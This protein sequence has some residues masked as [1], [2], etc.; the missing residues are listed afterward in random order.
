M[1]LNIK[2]LN[3]SALV[4]MVILMLSVRESLAASFCNGT[5][6][7]LTLKPIFQIQNIDLPIDSVSYPIQIGSSSYYSNNVLF[8]YCW[9]YNLR[10][11]ARITRPVLGKFNGQDVYDIGVPHMGIIV[12]IADSQEGGFAGGVN[13]NGNNLTSVVPPSDS[14]LLVA[15]LGASVKIGLIAFDRYPVGINVIPTIKI[16]ELSVVSLNGGVN[17]LGGV[18]DIILNGFSIEVKTKTCEL[19]QRNFT[20]PLQTVYKSMFNAINAEV[21]GGD[22]TLRLQC[23]PG[24]NVYATMTDAT[25]PANMTDILSLSQSSTAKGIKLKLYREGEGEAIKFGA[26][27]PVKGNLNQWKVT[28]YNGGPDPV[29]NIRANYIRT[30]DIMPGTVQA[31]STITFSY[32]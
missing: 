18:S 19:S 24:I 3:L 29:L 2:K 27:S 17:R 22:I 28:T 21:P 26:E 7:N 12:T 25:N 4:I 16:G 5:P 11:Q 1:T 32:Q 6:K 31:I 23:Q 8:D 20:V 9:P 30:G 14:W 15:R 10:E 13:M